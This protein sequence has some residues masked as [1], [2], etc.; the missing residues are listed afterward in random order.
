LRIDDHRGAVDI[1]DH[2]HR[3]LLPTRRERPCGYSA[4]KCDEV[5]PPHGAYPKAK[6]HGTKYS[7]CWGGSEA[8]I[9][10]KRSPYD[11][12]NARN[13]VLTGV[14]AG[15]VLSDVAALKREMNEEDLES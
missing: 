14:S 12:A 9:A 13:V 4:E 6:D 7:R 11:H 1:P 2:R 5:P 15:Y 10:I 3:R 8:R